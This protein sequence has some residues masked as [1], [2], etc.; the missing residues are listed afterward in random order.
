[1][2]THWIGNQIGIEILNQGVHTLERMIR[3]EPAR[4]ASPPTDLRNDFS[5]AEHILLGI[6]LGMQL[7]HGLVMTRVN[8]YLLEQ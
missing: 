5:P 8:G 4:H 2:G 3:R 1:M 7:Q 6:H